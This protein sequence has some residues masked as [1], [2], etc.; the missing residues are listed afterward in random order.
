MAEQLHRHHPLIGGEVELDI[1]DEA[2]KVGHD[3]D[4]FILKSPGEDQHLVVIRVKE[5]KASPA[6]GLIVF[7]EEDE[8]LHPPEEG[9]GILLLRLYVDGLVMMFRIDNDRR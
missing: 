5:F 1:V 8:P 7:A 9:A 6:E 3:Q 4:N 2:R